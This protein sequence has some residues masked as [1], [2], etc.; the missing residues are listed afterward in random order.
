MTNA[1]RSGGFNLQMNEAG[2]IL[3]FVM[4]MLNRFINSN[5]EVKLD[6]GFQ[7]FFKI[8]SYNHMNWSKSRRNKTARTLGCKNQDTEV[9]IA[10]CVDIPTGFPGQANVFQNKCLLTATIICSY[11]NKY[12]QNSKSDASFEKLKHLWTKRSPR[13]KKIQAGQFLQLEVEKVIETLQ[14]TDDGPYDITS[15]MPLLCNYFSSQIHIVKS[16]QEEIANIQSFPTTEWQTELLQIFLLQTEPNHVVP[17][18]NL[19]Q[20]ANKNNQVCLICKKTFH[21]YY[22]HFCSFKQHSCFL[23]KSYYAKESTIVKQNLHFTYCFSKLDPQL[24]TPMVCDVCNYKFPTKRCFENHRAICGVKSK[25]GRIGYFCDHC[26]KFIKGSNS[27]ETRRLHQCA[28]AT[29]MKCKHCKQLCEKDTSHQCLLTK[30]QL[31]KSW[32]K[33]IFFSFEFQSNSTFQCTT[34]QQLRKDFKDL[35]G[36]TWK[37]AYS[38]KKFESLKCS[39]HQINTALHT[40]NFCTVWKETT[41]GLFDELIFADDELNIKNE[42]TSNVFYFNYEGQGKSQATNSKFYGKQTETTKSSL[43]KILDKPQKSAVDYFILFLLTPDIRNH[44]FLSL[45]HCNENMATVLDCILTLDWPPT[46]LKKGNSF[47][48]LQTKCQNL[49]FLNASNYFKADYVELA[50]QFTIEEK[51]NFFPHR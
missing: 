12:F 26:N 37:E 27:I 9:K 47:V 14:L 3:S 29:Q 36:F 13:Y 11:A 35:G 7:V 40:P 45:N 1:L 30:E 31:T 39:H 42:V 28:S 38:Q 21:R 25:V 2:S 4:N 17:I 33:L 44:T 32:P 50:Q 48:L 23:C 34:C 43:K 20:Y 22:R 8:F 41:S 49:L 15:T 51:P 18:I 10:G 5:E 24:P 19:K 6:Q 16:T 46:L